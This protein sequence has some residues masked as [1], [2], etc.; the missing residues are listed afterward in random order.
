M[1]NIRILLL[2]SVL[3]SCTSE[4]T[5]GRK[6]RQLSGQWTHVESTDS[7]QKVLDIKYRRISGMTNLNVTRM[8]ITPTDTFESNPDYIFYDEG[9]VTFNG[10]PYLTDSISGDSVNLVWGFFMNESEVDYYDKEE[11][12]S[13][14]YLF[15]KTDNNL[16]VRKDSSLDMY[17]RRN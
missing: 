4:S 6:L 16:I 17:K 3:S 11:A 8:R 10:M 12:E 13:K 5:T 14:S 7:T 15:F 9:K 2:L 1:K